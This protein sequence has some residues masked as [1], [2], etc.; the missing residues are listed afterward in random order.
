MKV[1]YNEFDGRAA[2]WL[3][4]LIAKGLIM[5]GIVDER[6]IIDVEPSDLKG[7]TRHHF[8]AGIS[9]WELAL[10]L[11][12]WPIDRP[13]CSASLPC[14][15]FSTAGRQKGKDDERHLL[16]HF[17][18]LV[19]ECRFPVI[20]GEQVENALAHEWADDLVDELTTLNY[21]T[22]LSIIPA[23]A[24]GGYHIRSRLWWVAKQ[25]KSLGGFNDTTR[26]N[27]STNSETNKSEYIANLQSEI[28]NE[29]NAEGYGD[30]KNI[31]EGE[32]A[33]R[34]RLYGVVDSKGARARENE[35]GLREVFDGHS[36]MGNTELHGHTA[37]Q[38]GRS[39]GESETEGRMLQ[40][41]RPNTV[42]RLGNTEHDGR[43]AGQIATSDV[44]PSAK[45]GEN[46]ANLSRESSGA[47]RRVDATSLSGCQDG[48]TEWNNPDWIYCRDNKYRPIK[49]AF[50]G[51]ANG[52]PRGMVCSS[53]PGEPIDANNTQEARVMRLKAY[54]NSIVPQ[55]AASFINAFLE[56]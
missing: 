13:V 35:R 38:I 47:S 30:T 55:V 15:P 22:A 3:R 24:L 20:V 1:Y 33:D 4:Q 49:S 45:G 8:F 28:N 11:A 31:S 39:I 52:L 26:K 25:Q 41:E 48:R 44:Q 36:R 53:D 6:S 5:E 42:G 32:E 23:A 34:Q 51:M 21:E 54:G 29:E 50:I 56:I 16:P 12:N 17:I 10:Q 2:A 7:F 9:G 14:Q 40:L 18:E 19:K 37:S 46:R 27:E 43:A